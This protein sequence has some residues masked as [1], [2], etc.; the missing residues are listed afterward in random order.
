MLLAVVV[1]VVVRI[2][3]MIIWGEPVA[4]QQRDELTTGG[5][6][7]S[8]GDWQAGR[9]VAVAGALVDRIAA[10]EMLKMLRKRCSK[11]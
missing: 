9:A 2:A 11:M 4:A 10:V 8:G 3:P 1:V 7:V 6:L 5:G